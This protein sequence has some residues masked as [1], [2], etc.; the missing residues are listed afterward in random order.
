MKK[1]EA[2]TL[3][4]QFVK[5]KKRAKRTKKEADIQNLKSIENE[6]INRFK[7][8]V[9]MRTAKYR[10]F[11]NYE[12]L[13]QEGLLALSHAMQNY[14]PSKS[15]FYYWALR[16]IE[17][18]IAR[19]ANAHTAIRFPMRYAK[20]NTPY[21]ETKMPKLL[22]VVNCPD[23]IFESSEVASAVR[24][25]MNSLY[26]KQ[27]RVVELYFGFEDN[28]PMNVSRICKTMRIQRTCCLDMI[29]DALEVLKDSIKI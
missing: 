21:R 23:K 6:C 29:N 18:R 11:T 28:K 9:Y 8:L 3:I 4:K 22:D 2:Q 25:A 24:E 16:Y 20:I 19:S 17:T 10:G 1:D 7:F 27:K 26:G 15:S 13:N 12:D 14:D 5:A